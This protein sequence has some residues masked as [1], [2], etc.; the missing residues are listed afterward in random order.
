MSENNSDTFEET[1]PVDDSVAIAK[2]SARKAAED[3]RNAATAKAKALSDAAKSRATHLR[4]TAEDKAAEFRGYAD[5]RWSNA[6][7]KA[8]DFATEA[9]NY[10]REK[11]L[12]ALLAAFGIGFVIGAILK[13]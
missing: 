2:A 3:I 5:E 6:S 8:K 11:P 12:K 1:T 13:R 10:A 9:E 7:T 4:E